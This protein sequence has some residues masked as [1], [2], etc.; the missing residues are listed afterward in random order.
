MNN[1]TV[2]GLLFETHLNWLQIQRRKYQ[3]IGSS[4]PAE[5]QELQINLRSSWP[6]AG[7]GRIPEALYSADADSSQGFRV[8]HPRSPLLWLCSKA[9]SLS[10]SAHKENSHPW[11]QLRITVRTARSTHSRIISAA[12]TP[13]WRRP[14]PTSY[15]ACPR[16]RGSLRRCLCWGQR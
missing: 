2:K 10:I 14:A 8:S 4:P 6:E 9:S 13:D 11:W 5:C 7:L 1:F 15:V 12:R 16:D 3:N